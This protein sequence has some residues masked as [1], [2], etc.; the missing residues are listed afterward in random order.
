MPGKQMN[1]NKAKICIIT[2]SHLCRNP[3]VLKESQALANEGYIVEI[4]TCVISAD[5]YSQDLAAIAPYPGISLNIISNLSN[6]SF[7]SIID[8]LLNKFGKSLTRYFKVQT[9]LALGYGAIRYFKKVKNAKAALYICH[10]ELA[11]FIGTKLLKNG[12]KVAFDLE[13]W[14]SEDL[15][16][17]A[18]SGRPINLLQKI[19]YKALNKGA[20]CFTTSHAMAKRL[21]EVYFC[22]Q[23]EVL[24]NVFPS[25]TA[26][27]N[28]I[29][30]SFSSPLKLFWF[31]Q[32]I[33]EGRGLEQFISLIA[34]FK[35]TVEIHL[36]GHVNASYRETLAA[37]FPKQHQLYFHA[38]VGTHQLAAKIAAFDIGLALEL[39]TPPSRDLTLTNK[40]FQYLQSGLPVIASET[41]GQN[42][43]FDKFTPGYQISQYPNEQ[44]IAKLEEWLNDPAVLHAARK[45]AWQAAGFYNWENES[46]K[47]LHMVNDFLEMKP[48][49]KLPV[50][51]TKAKR[52]WKN[53]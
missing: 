2:Q 10:Q 9:S 11:T 38:M 46:K 26:E 40:F 1:A 20:F 32:T 23:P 51:N 25:P 52:W 13:D 53:L 36:L 43:V 4:F 3:R 33:G 7:L 35:N 21:A 50:C 15:L 18:R 8:R 5:L 29:S 45:R 17:E 47:L 37:L 19:E 6:N 16:P 39:D 28:S 44:E 22:T 41:A 42:E 14:Y 30:K 49:Y 12:F 34:G 48:V 24:Y 31:S 27:I